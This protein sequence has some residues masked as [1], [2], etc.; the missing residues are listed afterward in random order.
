MRGMVVGAM[1]AVPVVVPAV[2]VV[3]PAAASV[4]SMMRHDD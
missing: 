4:T 2:P 3:M 1:P